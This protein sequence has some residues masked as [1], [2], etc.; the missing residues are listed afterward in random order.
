VAGNP[1]LAALIKQQRS[2]EAEAE[3]LKLQKGDMPPAEWQSAYEKLM[4]E[5]ARVSQEIRKKS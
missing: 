4:L 2:L 1:E 3:E 5:L